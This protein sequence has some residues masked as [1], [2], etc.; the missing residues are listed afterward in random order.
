MQMQTACFSETLP[1][2][3]ESA[4]RQ[5]PKEHNILPLPP[6]LHHHHHRLEDF[7]FLM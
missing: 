6:P 4:L 3:D 7:K 2:I 5:N 1:P